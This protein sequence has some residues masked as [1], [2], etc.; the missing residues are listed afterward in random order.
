MFLSGV[1]TVNGEES[2][3]IL[4]MKTKRKKFLKVQRAFWMKQDTFYIDCR[5]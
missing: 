2:L 5:S 4:M 3:A 1:N